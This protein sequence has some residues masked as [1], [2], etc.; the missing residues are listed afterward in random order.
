MGG[1]NDDQN[2]NENGMLHK[3]LHLQAGRE[4]LI[5]YNANVKFLIH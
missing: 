2:D 4:L 3:K 1:N 5:S